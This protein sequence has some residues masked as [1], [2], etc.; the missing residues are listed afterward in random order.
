MNQN[1]NFSI[2]IVPADVYGFK[3]KKRWRRWRIK[4]LIICLWIL[5][6]TGRILIMLRKS[7]MNHYYYR[8][9]LTREAN[10]IE[11]DSRFGV[12]MILCNFQPFQRRPIF[13]R[14]QSG[15]LIISH[16]SSLEGRISHRARSNQLLHKRVVAG[17]RF[18]R[19]VSL[20][21]AWI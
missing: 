4:A 3:K 12:K 13:D 15:Q 1:N 8:F 5:F 7:I 9:R 11:S 16:K 10:E 14:S 21:E 2:S 17:F 20:A 19:H 6:L 18:V